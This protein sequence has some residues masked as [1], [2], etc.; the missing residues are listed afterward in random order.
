MVCAAHRPCPA[1][2]GTRSETA[3]ADNGF[4]LARCAGCRT[5]FTSRLPEQADAHDYSTYYSAATPTVPPL[6]ERRLDELVHRME[7]HRRTGRWLDVGFGAGSLMRAGA[8]AG[9]TVT[10]TEVSEPTAE[11]MSSA[12]FDVRVGPRPEL[13]AE[14][15]DVAT[16]LE[17]VEHVPDPHAML[18][19]IR[20]ALRPGGVLY[21]TTPNAGG[22]SARLLGTRWSVVAPPEHLQLFSAAGL[23][24]LCSAT[25][26]SERRIHAHGLNPYELASVLRHKHEVKL[27]GSERVAKGYRVNEMLSGGPARRRAKDL[28]NRVLSATRL[29]DSLK[30]EAERRAL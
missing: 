29:G 1:C 30:L 17:V 12:G 24:A 27:G 28:A 3:G 11:A 8:R 9:W 15:F 14:A 22:L 18:N 20:A 13:E 10:G 21:L 16:A 19:A 6:V 7:P 23:R 25:G 4:V 5:W 2:A 26:F